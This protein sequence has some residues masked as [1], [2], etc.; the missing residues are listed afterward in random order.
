[1]MSLIPKDTPQGRFAMRLQKAGITEIKIQ[2]NCLSITFDTIKKDGGVLCKASCMILTNK[3]A[4]KREFRLPGNELLTF[5]QALESF[6]G[7]A[8]GWTKLA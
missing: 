3:G 5:D 7:D 4:Y 1:M 2:N 8:K 6:F